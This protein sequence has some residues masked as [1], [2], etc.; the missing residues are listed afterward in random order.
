MERIY[1]PWRL[2]QLWHLRCFSGGTVHPW[3][4][5]L[6]E[7]LWFEYSKYV[8]N[9]EFISLWLWNIFHSMK[10]ITTNLTSQWCLTQTNVQIE[11][12][13]A[14]GAML[15]KCKIVF[16]RTEQGERE[17]GLGIGKMWVLVMTLSLPSLSSLN[18]R[19][20]IIIIVSEGSLWALLNEV[21][22]CTEGTEMNKTN[23]SSQRSLPKEDERKWVLT[24]VIGIS[25]GCHKN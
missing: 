22:S 12:F 9:K 2:S 5:M 8:D 15:N 7:R 16:H 3:L 14:N 10:Q 23:L 19:H 18:M 1:H 11:L 17:Q 4:L 25:T 13:T 21:M 24:A 20:Y 6:V